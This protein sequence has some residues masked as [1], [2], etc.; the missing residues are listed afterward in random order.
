M[1]T[2][3]SFYKARGMG[4][5]A[6]TG[7]CGT[8]TPPARLSDGQLMARAAPPLL[9]SPLRF[10]YYEFWVPSAASPVPQPERPQPPP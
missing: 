4:R 2:S 7:G 1:Q 5:G 6:R 8:P 3:H 9:S 10:L